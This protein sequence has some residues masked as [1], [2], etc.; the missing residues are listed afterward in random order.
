M[1]VS[2][3][4]ALLGTAWAVLA[5]PLSSFALDEVTSAS[6]Q[7]ESVRALSQ[8]GRHLDALRLFSSVAENEI[9]LADR[10]AA[11]KSAWALGLVERAR[12]LWRDAFSV[13]E[14]TGAERHREQ[15]A[16]AIMELQENNGEEARAIAEKSASEMSPS[17]LRSQFWLLIGESLK[18]QGAWSQA[19]SYYRRAGEESEGETKNEAMFLL[20]D[21]QLKLGLINDARYSFA[22][23][24][25]SS[26]YAAKAIRQLAE[27]DL[28]Q[29]NYEGV[30]TWISEGE[31]A[32]PDSFIDP[33]VGYA[34]VTSLIELHRRSDAEKILD[35]LRVRFSEKEPWFALAQAAFEG[36]IARGQFAL[37]PKES[38]E[39]SK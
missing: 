24:S 34:H 39:N 23:V 1:V 29:R 14:F 11:A 27:I 9:T 19:E 10:L 22:N 35:G 18:K 17:D 32:S 31:A 20:G 8:D 12:I 16:W 13:R 7:T 38:P 36:A 4:I 2:R 30:L 28:T 6:I 15:L 25:T 3:K 37:K 33:W 21:C 26:K 5:A